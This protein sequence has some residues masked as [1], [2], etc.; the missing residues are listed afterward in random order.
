M[1]DRNP[2]AAA[3][4][5]SLIGA[6]GVYAAIAAIFL[7]PPIT[8]L[9][10]NHHVALRI[11]FVLLAVVFSLLSATGSVLGFL[12]ETRPGRRS[13]IAGA[14]MFFIGLFGLAIAWFHHVP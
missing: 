11:A 7:V 1:N 12:A 2:L 8:L 9:F 5:W 6:A 3:S 10:F 13:G 4:F 14:L